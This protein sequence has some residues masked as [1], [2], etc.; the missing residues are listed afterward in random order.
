MSYKVKIYLNK[1]TLIWPSFYYTT[2]IF[3]PVP[4]LESALYKL[5]L[6]N[7]SIMIILYFVLWTEK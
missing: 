5:Q 7:L 6:S 3:K 1:V 4:I 2:A